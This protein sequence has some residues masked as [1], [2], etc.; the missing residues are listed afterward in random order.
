M[1]LFAA[2]AADGRGVVAGCACAWFSARA[3]RRIWAEEDILD[4]VALVATCEQDPRDR[5]RVVPRCYLQRLTRD[6][7]QA[8]TA[9]HAFVLVILRPKAT[10]SADAAGGARRTDDERRLQGLALLA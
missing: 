6:A 8:V 9:D 4:F 1:T 10:V 3:R 7:V 2:A 5:K